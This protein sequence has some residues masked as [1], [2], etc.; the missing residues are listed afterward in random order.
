MQIGFLTAFLGGILALLSPCSALLLPAFLASTV[1]AKLKLL[2]HGAVFYLGLVV[3]LVPFGLGIGALGSLL[4]DHR[5]IVI[6]ITS[7]VLVVLGALQAL[8]FGFDLSRIL[9]GAAKTQQTAHKRTGLLRTFLLGAVGGVAGFCAGPILGAV[10]TLAMGR[11]NTWEAGA[12]LA[13][14]GAGMVV[15]LVLIA[16][17]WERLGPRGQRLLRGR[18]ITILGRSLHTTSLVTGLLIVAVGLL[19]WFTNGLVAMPSLVPTSV[20]AWMQE[21]GAILANPVFDIVAV[22]AVAA[23]ALTVWSIRT[24]ARRKQ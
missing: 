10:L 3:T 1:G 4:M 16:A 8:G 13:V 18:T 9:P 7:I 22:I 2:A 17:L 24:S 20:Q 12:L 6:A 14:Y 15:P 11:G 23:V 21:Q 19:F 5:G